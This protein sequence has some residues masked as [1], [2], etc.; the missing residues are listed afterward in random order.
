MPNEESL[1]ETNKILAIVTTPD[2]DR[3]YVA[4]LMAQ[5]A[6]LR[7]MAVDV[8]FAASGIAAVAKNSMDDL[9]I[10]LAKEPGHRVPENIEISANAQE[11]ATYLMREGMVGLGMPSIEKYLQLTSDTGAYIY[12]ESAAMEKFHLTQEDLW[13]GVKAVL[14]MNSFYKHADERTQ[15]IFL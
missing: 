5:G 15:V 9:G 4:L 3:V 1:R 7:G 11:A 2:L 13:A 14:P 6:R 10:S 12:A 8:M